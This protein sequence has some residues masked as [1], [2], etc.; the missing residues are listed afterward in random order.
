VEIGFAVVA[1]SALWQPHPP[2]P[3]QVAPQ[4]PQLCTVGTV[5]A[6]HLMVDGK[7]LV[8][9]G[10]VHLARSALTPQ[11]HLQLQIPQVQVLGRMQLHLQQHQPNAIQQYA[12]LCKVG[13]K[14]RARIGIV[15]VA[16]SA[17]LQ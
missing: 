4:V 2:Q 3:T 1:L 10:S 11:R 16:L 17:R 8:G 12:A 5:Y 13:G 15:A 14:S 7:K 6:H 9:N